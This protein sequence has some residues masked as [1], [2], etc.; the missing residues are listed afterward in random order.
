MKLGIYGTGGSGR[1]VYDIITMNPTTKE[2]WSEIIFIDDTKEKGTFRNCRMMPFEDLQH[3]I[4]KDDIKIV[5]AVGEPTSRK[6]LYDRVIKNGIQLATVIHPLAQISASAKIGNG[7]VIQ[8]NVTVSSDAVVE[9]NAYINSKSIVGHDAHIGMH[10]QISSFSIVAGG[11]QV[12]KETYIGISAAIRDHI[13]IGHN[14]IVSMGAVVVKDVR[15]NMVVMGN[16]AR[17]IAE[18]KGKVFK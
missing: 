8:E 12:G 9:D 4:E 6:K 3:D 14:V 13:R 17:E 7:A 16:P 18:N 10:C 1:E 2:Y 15:D 11:T 5:I